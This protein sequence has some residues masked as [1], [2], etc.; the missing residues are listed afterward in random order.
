MKTFFYFGLGMLVSLGA[1]IVTYVA[2]PVELVSI[3]A[4]PIK[5][6]EEL[7]PVC[8]SVIFHNITQEGDSSPEP[9]CFIASDNALFIYNPTPGAEDS[10]I[11]IIPFTPAELSERGMD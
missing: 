9:I 5:E 11:R 7:E 8:G 6:A 1:M 3:R 4:A 10:H 2:S